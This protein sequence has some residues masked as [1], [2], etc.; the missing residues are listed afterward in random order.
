MKVYMN[1]IQTLDFLYCTY[2]QIVR[3]KNEFWSVDASI[4]SRGARSGLLNN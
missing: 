4:D 3:L 2:S 1:G